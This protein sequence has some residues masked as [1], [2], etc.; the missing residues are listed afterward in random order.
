MAF[1]VYLVGDELRTEL[2]QVLHDGQGVANAIRLLPHTFVQSLHV[3]DEESQ[4]LVRDEGV[5]ESFSGL[6][7]ISQGVCVRHLLKEVHHGH[8]DVCV[9]VGDQ[10]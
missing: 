3:L 6:L 10:A 9:L 8:R 1:C 2:N 4:H 5:D 7:G